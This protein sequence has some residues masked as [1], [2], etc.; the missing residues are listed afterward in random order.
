MPNIPRI[1]D[2]APDFNVKTHTGETISLSS[3]KGRWVVLYFFPKAFT[4]GCTSETKSFA[5]LWNRFRNIGAFVIGISRD[6][7]T[8]ARFARE[9]GV[10]FVLVSDSD[11]TIA[12]SYG[13]LGLLGLAVRVTFIIDPKGRIAGIIKGFSIRPDKHPIEALKV[14]E[15][16]SQ[17]QRDYVT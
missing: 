6:D 10:N 2:E 11:G 16:K 3:L 8:L 13:V 4:P 1:G 7:D 9:Y 17:E 12:R 14:I 15:Q 5:S